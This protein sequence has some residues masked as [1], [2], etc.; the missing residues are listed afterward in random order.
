MLKSLNT[1]LTHLLKH[2]KLH[3]NVQLHSGLHK[4]VQRLCAYRSKI[5]TTTHLIYGMEIAQM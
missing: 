2:H 4:I 3:G 5:T 1:L